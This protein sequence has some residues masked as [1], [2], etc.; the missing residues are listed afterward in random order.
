MERTSWNTGLFELIASIGILSLRF[1]RRLLSF[2][3]TMEKFDFVEFR[4]KLRF[5]VGTSNVYSNFCS[6]SLFNILD[7]H[8][9][10]MSNSWIRSR[11]IV[12]FC[13]LILIYGIN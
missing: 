13:E 6:R 5:Q 9:V 2:H 10:L 1:H 8:G 11:L 3:E 12:I 7:L 4:E